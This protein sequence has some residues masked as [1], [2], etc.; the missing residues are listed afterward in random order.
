MGAW[1]GM[2]M[3]G[4][5]NEPWGATVFKQK[6]RFSLPGVPV[7]RIAHR[8]VAVP[9]A[10][11]LAMSLAMTL[12]M[13]LAACGGGPMHIGDI[14]PVVQERLSGAWVLNADE[15]D[16]PQEA[17]AAAR[18]RE[19]T[20]ARRPGGGA[21]PG[22]GAMPP[23][24]GGMPGTG[25]GGMTGAGGRGG[26]P[27]G[28]AGRGAMPGGGARGGGNPEALRT[29]MRLVTV[30]PRRL[31]VALSDSLVKVG[32]T[33]QDVWVLPFGEKVKRNLGDDMT[34]EA[35]A[36]WDNDRLVVR[37]SVSGGGSVTETYMPSADGRR[38]TVMVEM[39]GGPGGG[40]EVRRV[41]DAGPAR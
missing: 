1:A 36:E 32:Y 6:R 25:R 13:G 7:L 11:T 28:A 10:M 35:K 22:G 26:M 23:G 20:G 39:S 16:D 8:P 38:L 14:T 21:Q 4:R 9:L 24:G 40:F 5:I 30:P 19:G 27:G 18:P 29:L 17:M 12:A 41:Y 2:G 15:S 31:A 37:R 33:A 3:Q 34:L